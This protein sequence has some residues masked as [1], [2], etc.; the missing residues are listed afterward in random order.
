M[1]CNVSSFTDAGGTLECLPQQSCGC[2]GYNND[3]F[4]I[5]TDCTAC[6][7]NVSSSN[8]RY[9][10]AGSC[11]ACNSTLAVN[12]TTEVCWPAWSKLDP[13]STELSEYEE[14]PSYKALK[15]LAQSTA[16]ILATGTTSEEKI[17]A[18]V[19]MTCTWILNNIQEL[20]KTW[21]SG[22][23]IAIRSVTSN[24]MYENVVL[25][26][27]QESRNKEVTQKN[28]TVLI[29]AG[30]NGVW[31]LNSGSSDLTNQDKK[32]IKNTKP[33]DDYPFR[34]ET[35][36]T[37]N[38]SMNLSVLDN[39]KTE[40]K[41]YI[42]YFETNISLVFE[43]II[44]IDPVLDEN[45]NHENDLYI[46]GKEYAYPAKV[47]DKIINSITIVNENVGLIIG[48]FLD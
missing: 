23:K 34:N 25:Y 42:I 24:N 20:K 35:L 36:G 44:N 40:Y 6:S 39:N 14:S 26:G 16:G 12:A 9:F 3:V 13:L 47:P 18:I 8:L 43:K 5:W 15:E 41:N 27:S 11:V 28:S 37:S 2:G 38:S 19:R 21:L 1:A 4:Y 7:S 33:Y 17:K 46:E 45:Y 32:V 29:P 48:V 22:N 31:C 30:E 10:L